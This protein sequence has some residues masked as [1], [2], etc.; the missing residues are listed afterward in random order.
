MAKSNPPVGALL[1]ASLTVA[2]P[3]PTAPTGVTPET[4]GVD[5]QIGLGGLL[6]IP[7]G[8]FADD[9]A[10]AHGVSA[11]VSYRFDGIPV[12][13][14]AVVAS[15][16]Y[17]GVTRRMPLQS[18]PR[19]PSNTPFDVTTRNKLLMAHGRIRL[20]ATA[21]TARPYVDGLFGL[22]RLYTQTRFISVNEDISFQ[23]ADF[24][25]GAGRRG[26][27]GSAFFSG[28]MVGTATNFSSVTLS[29]GGGGGVLV[30]LATW[31]RA[32][33][34]LDLGAQYVY[35]GESD[36]LVADEHGQEIGSAVLSTRRSP[37][38]IFLLRLGTV[39]SF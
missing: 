26:D 24:V 22:T 37:V 33:L 38:N 27:G 34:R 20:Q 32:R 21:G 16:S 30:N 10:I 36:Y 7:V 5:L 39:L 25:R 6:G 31:S 19:S 18:D 12:Q 11:D 1:S 28:V 23:V 4:N 3:A 2:Q 14:G 9:V 17:D 13:V 35:A 8:D 29:G 15:L